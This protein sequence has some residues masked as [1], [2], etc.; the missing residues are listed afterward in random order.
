VHLASLGH[1][2]LADVLYGGKCIEPAQRQM[3]HARALQ[4]DDPGGQGDLA[5][6]APVPQDMRKVQEATLWT[7]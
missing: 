1:P 5:F 7:A 3:L 6:T 2:L 4:F